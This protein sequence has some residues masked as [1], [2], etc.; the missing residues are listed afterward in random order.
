MSKKLKSYTFY[1]WQELRE[2]VEAESG[3]SLIDWGGKIKKSKKDYRSGNYPQDFCNYLFE[4][5]FCELN[6]G[7]IFTFDPK[8]IL[9]DLKKE[10]RRTGVERFEKE[11]LEYFIKVMEN[12]NL[13][14]EINVHY[15]W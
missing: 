11:V 7:C 2:L 14:D 15:Y 5:V 1:E 10:E 6:N 12:N 9:S 3:R 4:E 8:E 13:P